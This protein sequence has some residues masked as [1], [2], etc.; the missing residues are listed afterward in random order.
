MATKTLR[1]GYSRYLLY[2]QIKRDYPYRPKDLMNFGFYLLSQKKNQKVVD[3]EPLPREIVE[4]NTAVTY[5]DSYQELIQH[6]MKSQHTSYRAVIETAIQLII[7]NID[8]FK[9]IHFNSSK[10]PSHRIRIYMSDEEFNDT[11]KYAKSVGKSIN[12]LATDCLK[13]C[14]KS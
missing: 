7:D 14:I 5:D 11:I 12:E 13:T 3:L 1:I 8:S 9:L 6:I 2:F 10:N 4:T